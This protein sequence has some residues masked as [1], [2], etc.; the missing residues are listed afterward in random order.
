M[1][2]VIALIVRNRRLLLNIVGIIIVCFAIWWYVFHIPAKLEEA[3]LKRDYYKKELS[4]AK[5]DAVLIQD[6]EKGRR[7]VDDTI[8]TQISSMRSVPLPHG[9]VIIRAGRVLPPLHEA[10]YS[11]GRT[12]PNND[13]RSRD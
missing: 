12:A 6:I 9:S 10:S 2:L 5:A 1:T 4:A 11:S 13:S 3:E 7:Q 8:Q